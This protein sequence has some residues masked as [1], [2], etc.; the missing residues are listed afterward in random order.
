MAFTTAD[1][2]AVERA[3]ASGSKE[4]SYRDRRVTYQSL[5]DL[6]TLRSQMQSELGTA[7]TGSMIGGRR[8]AAVSKG[9]LPESR[10]EEW[11]RA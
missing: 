10:E 7:A 8:I 3:I 11:H 9:V 5:A 1:L 4:V 2:E 6:L